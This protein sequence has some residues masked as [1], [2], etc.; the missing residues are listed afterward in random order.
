MYVSADCFYTFYAFSL[1][2][3]SPDDTL[4]W[5]LLK[6][7]WLYPNQ[8]N[9]RPIRNDV[10]NLTNVWKKNLKKNQIGTAKYYKYQVK[11]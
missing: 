11:I 8:R 9:L 6:T 4:F 10:S 7:F 2:K 3:P 1:D 5:L